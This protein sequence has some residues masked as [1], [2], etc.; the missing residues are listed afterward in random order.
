MFSLFSLFY[1]VGVRR[2]TSFLLLAVSAL[3]VATAFAQ[4]SRSSRGLAAVPKDGVKRALLVGVDDYAEF[5]DLKYAVA[6]VE[7]IRGRLVE[8]GFKPENIVELKST[9]P[10][11]LRPSQR[12]IRRQVDALLKAAGP[13]DLLFLHF[14]GHGFQSDGVVRFA[15]EDA[16]ATGDE[17]VVDPETTISLTEIIERLKTSQAK[18]KW[19]I[20][21]ACRENPT[22]TRS[23]AANARALKNIDPPKGMLVLQ[24]C[25]EGEL[26]YEDAE[27]G[28]GLFTGRLLEAFDGKADFD[29]DGAMSALDVCKY[30]SEQTLAAS[31]KRFNAA[32]TPRA[33]AEDFGDFI[34]AEDLKVDGLGRAEWVRADSLYEDAGKLIEAEDYETAQIK[35]DEA[36]KIV[37]D[38]PE[39]N[40][41]KKRYAIQ[42]RMIAE[43]VARFPEWRRE[44]GKPTKIVSNV[45]ELEEAVANA[46]D[47]DVIA[48]MD[49]EY[50]LTKFLG[51][52]GIK[53]MLAA[54]SGDC[55]SVKIVSDRSDAFIIDQTEERGEIALADL[56]IEAPNDSAVRVI[57]GGEVAI[58]RCSLSAGGKIGTICCQNGSVKLSDCKLVNDCDRLNMTAMIAENSVMDARR[59]N[60]D[61]QVTLLGGSGP[62]MFQKCEFHNSP[63]AG[64]SI[65]GKE[66]KPASCELI[67]CRVFNCR[68]GVEA[69][70]RGEAR[71]RECEILHCRN[72]EGNGAGVYAWQSGSITL[73][74]VR[75]DDCEYGV[76]SV[77]NGEVTMR[78]GIIRNCR[79]DVTKMGIG[80]NAYSNGILKLDSVKISDCNIGVALNVDCRCEARR[81]VF[82]N[83]NDKWMIVDVASRATHNGRRITNAD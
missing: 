38:V 39:T 72:S 30:V 60:F 57:G 20:V 59:C 77:K 74:D 68:F 18:F 50:R 73:E 64:I 2:R 54:Q 8:L 62:S 16:I 21:D 10:A 1:R 31:K 14:S 6:D 33:T 79:N 24:S 22:G 19:L 46:K 28:R 15:P 66:G 37:A 49:G 51:V 25:S 32:Q 52:S 5:A 61:G 3:T 44:F 78:N 45:A 27:N 42:K 65:G 13:N 82:T 47:G 75:I 43:V 69:A 67:D 83:V 58:A 55:R 41:T 40:Q 63:A 7:A 36:L 70:Y 34:I 4:E 35:I 48:L 26:S 71:V 56:T 81:L 17:E 53:L 76:W 23:A 29:G 11:N 80:V 12:Y 9:S